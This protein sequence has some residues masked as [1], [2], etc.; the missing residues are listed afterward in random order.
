MKLWKVKIIWK[1]Y[2]LPYH[3]SYWRWWVKGVAAVITSVAVRNTAQ[4]EMDELTGYNHILTGENKRMSRSIRCLQEENKAMDTKND[5]LDKKLDAKAAEIAAMIQTITALQGENS[6]LISKADRLS[7]ALEELTT[8]LQ[9]KDG[10]IMSLQAQLD[11]LSDEVNAWQTGKKRPWEVSQKASPRRDIITIELL[12]RRRRTYSEGALAVL[13]IMQFSAS[14]IYLP[15]FRCGGIS[16]RHIR[17]G[18]PALVP[19]VQVHI[20]IGPR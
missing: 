5:D 17:I 12:S 2:C 14:P 6:L 3:K 11:Q 1:H 19:A 7:R 13:L 20:I 15:F 8:Q 9:L 10:M 18:H 4:R 16:N